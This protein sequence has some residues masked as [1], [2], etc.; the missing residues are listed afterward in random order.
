[1]EFAPSLLGE[2]GYKWT[3]DCTADTLLPLAD[4]PWTDQ[5]DYEIAVQA[6]RRGAEWGYRNACT[7]FDKQA[8]E[9]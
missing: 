8:V 7:R 9:N 4:I 6:W 1:M 3:H 5:L 2:T